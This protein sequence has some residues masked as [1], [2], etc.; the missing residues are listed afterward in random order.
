VNLTSRQGEG[1]H[2]KPLAVVQQPKIMQ[3]HQDFNH[4]ERKEHKDKN[5]WHF[6]FAI[7]VFFAVNSFLVAAWGLCGERYFYP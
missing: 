5:L 1:G 6:F 3:F 7:F 2:A 4:K